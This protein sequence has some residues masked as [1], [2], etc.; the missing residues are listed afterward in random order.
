MSIYREDRLLAL[1]HAIILQCL[2]DIQTPE[3]RVH[4]WNEVW[5]ALKVYA[6]Y[7]RM[8]PSE[9]VKSAIRSG[10]IKGMTESEVDNYGK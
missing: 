9:M 3:K 5:S 1:Q 7:Y 6:P 10:Y 8:T 4:Y 2:K